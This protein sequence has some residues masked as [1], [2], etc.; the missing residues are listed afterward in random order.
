MPIP[1]PAFDPKAGPLMGWHAGPK[2]NL[3]PGDGYL[4]LTALNKNLEIRTYDLPDYDTTLTVT[5]DGGLSG[6]DTML[7][8][9]A[10]PCVCTA[11]TMHIESIIAGTA[12]KRGRRKYGKV[13]VTILD[14]YGSPVSGANV[15][16]TFTGDYNE[17]ITGTTGTNG[18]AVITTS[19]YVRRPSYT[20]CVDDLSHGTLTYDPNDNIEDCKSR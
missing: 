11:T 9:A 15:T 10:G 1:N 2:T 5:D 19:A 12:R 13:T 20:F 17:T 16:G 8:A 4:A 7:L 6:T 14:E 18:K 3:E